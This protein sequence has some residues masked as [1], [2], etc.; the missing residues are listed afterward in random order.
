MSMNQAK[1]LPDVYR[2]D[3]GSNNYKIMQL[4]NLLNTDFEADMK[5][6]FNSRDI[7][8]A[9]GKTLDKYGEMVGQSRNGATDEQYRF[10]I[11]YKISRLTAESDC[12]SIIA[13]LSQLFGSEQGEISISESNSSVQINGITIDM[14]NNSGFSMD[15]VKSM[16][17]DLLPV[18]VSA[19]RTVFSGSLL[20]NSRRE[21]FG[22]PDA[23][24]NY[25]RL[26][27][28]WYLAQS[29]Y[30]YHGRDVGL[31]GSGTVPNIFDN[32]DGFSTSGT[33]AGGTLSV[34]VS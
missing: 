3:T 6:I 9:K 2:R 28:A 10:L 23:V 19:G 34:I 16:V 12:D 21:F 17:T 24:N 5:S 4:C 18:G 1:K 27:S 11:L 30:Y 13:S 32:G 8:N 26:Y 25:P 14:A 20:V 29:E 7:N 33:Y 31:S 22:N 15:E